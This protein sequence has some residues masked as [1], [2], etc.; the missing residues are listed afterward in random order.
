MNSID[1]MKPTSEEMSISKEWSSR[2]LSSDLSNLAFSFYYGGELST[3]LIRN[4]QTN[5]LSTT[6]DDLREKHSLIISE[7]ENGLEIQFILTEYANYP[8]FEWVV[9]FEN[10]GN[11]KTPIISDIQSANLTLFTGKNSPCILHHA[12]GSR[13]RITDF[14]PKKDILVP[15]E[16]KKFAPYGGRSSDGVLP[17]FNL[18]KPN[19][20]GI[21]TGVGWTGQWQASFNCQNSGNIN[22]SAG[23][24]VTKL[25]LFPGQKIRT[26]AILLLFYNGNRMRGQNHLRRLLRTHFTPSF[27]H[28]TVSS[29]IS[30]SPHAKVA[31]ES[32]S[33]TNMIEGIKLI[34]GANLPVDTWWVDAGWY[35]CQDSKA[36]Q[37]N[38]ARWVGNWTPD[39]N[40][41][42]N[43]VKPV[44]DAA[45]QYGLNFLLWFEPER[46]M[47]DSQTYK[48]HNDWLLYTEKFPPDQQ[49]QANDGFHLLNLANSSTLEWL[50]LKIS[51]I[52]NEVGIDI[53][54]HDFNMYPLNYWRHNDTADQQGITEICYIMGLYS[55]F[56]HLLESHETLIIDNCASGGRRIDFEMLRRSLLLWRSDLC[57]DPVAQQSATYGL[58]FWL[59]LHGV[60]SIS[61]DPYHFRSGMG[62]NFTLALDYYDDPSIWN[63]ATQLLAEYTEVKDIF[64]GDFYPLTDY[65]TSQKSWIAWQF[66]RPDLGVGVIQAFR[67][68]E[69]NSNL[70]KFTLQ[71]LQSDIQ[72]KVFNFDTGL[73]LKAC[74][75]VL[76]EDGLELNIDNCP[77]SV[78]IKYSVS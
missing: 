20:T 16:E 28:Q 72:Y 61:L 52:I 41:Y 27:N 70:R 34:S 31:F 62:S 67:R 76:M 46:V 47:I 58:S 37:H 78:T 40:R 4:W 29:P 51:S 77:G 75:Y 13:A 6:V 26:P 12:E 53:Y 11:Y 54:R 21:I 69:N 17:F 43:G 33:S 5:Q 7:P 60:G 42:P 38:W 49:Y 2:F 66:D 64:S 68:Q 14:Q 56:D 63:S 48:D 35:L 55:F 36:G 32:T 74:G 9:Y 19:R 15:G 10:K 44:A 65:S 57:W 1:L 30:A 18:E 59:P 23:M 50:K 73:Q 22:F 24:E 39:P 45:H 8:A 25:T 3:D 71:G